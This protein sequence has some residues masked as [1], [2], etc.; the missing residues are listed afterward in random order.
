M[1]GKLRVCIACYGKRVPTCMRT[2][3]DTCNNTTSCSGVGTLK[4]LGGTIQQEGVLDTA[5][6]L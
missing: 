6:K 3:S 2:M 1:H 5:L 4:C